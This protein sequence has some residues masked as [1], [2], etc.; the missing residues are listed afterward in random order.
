MP[1]GDMFS[2]VYTLAKWSLNKLVISVL[3]CVMEPL[4]FCKQLI[5][6]L[7]SSLESTY[8]QNTFWLVLALQVI[9]SSYDLQR[10]KP[11]VKL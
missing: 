11:I 8:F 9:F 1:Y 4:G 6:N 10:E 3:V 7:D 5:L 2:L